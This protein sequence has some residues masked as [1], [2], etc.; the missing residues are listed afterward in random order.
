M[1][2]RPFHPGARCFRQLVI[3]PVTALLFRWWINDACNVAGSPQHES[4]IFTLT[5]IDQIGA[6]KSTM[7]GHDMVFARSI[8]KA[9]YLHLTKINRITCNRQ[10][11]RN[12]QIILQIHIAQVVAKHRTGQVGAIRIPVQQIKGRRRFAF[13]VIRF[14]IIPDQIIRS[15]TGKRCGKITARHQTTLAYRLLSLRDLSFIDIHIDRTHIGEIQH[16]G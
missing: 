13:E 1:L 7:P 3:A 2:G 12:F 16:S 15:K 4:I 8:N 14:H 10:F 9:R 11:A 6:R 5:R